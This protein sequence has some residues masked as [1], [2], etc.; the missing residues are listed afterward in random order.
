MTKFPLRLL[1]LLFLLAGWMHAATPVVSGLRV[2]GRVSPLG[3]DD[4][5]PALSWR[6]E[7]ADRGA[8]QTAYRVLVASTAE[9]LTQDRGDLWDTGRVESEDNL[10]LVYAGVQL[11]SHQAGFWKVQ[12][13]DEHGQSSSWSPVATW[14]AGV[15]AEKDWA[16]TTRWISDP[17][18]L[19]WQRAKLGYRSLP[20]AV[21]TTPKWIQ[22]DLGQSLP[23]TAVRLRGVTHTVDE[24]LGF[25]RRYQLEVADRADFS[26][27]R[28]VA[29]TDK[30]TNSWAGLI[31]LPLKDITARYVRFTATQLRV[32][33]GEACLAISQI[34]VL[35]GGRNIAPTAKITASDTLEDAS[36]SLAAINDGLGI[37]GVNP[38]ASD[39]LRLRRTF[40]VRPG[41]KRALLTISGLGHYTLAVNGAPTDANRLLTPGWTDYRKTCLY[42]TH[43]L[44]AQ[45]R[46]GA[47]ALGLTLGGGMYNVQTGFNRYIKFVSAYRPLMATGELR[48]EYADGTTDVISTDEHWRVTPGPITFSN[49]FGG[50][51][52]DA[53]REIPGWATAEFNDTAWTPA[54]VT[55][56]PGGKLRGAAWASPAL[57]AHESFAPVSVR[58]LSAGVSVYDFGQNVAMMPRLHVHGPAGAMVRMI[59][60]ELLQADGAVDRGSVGGGKAYWQY[61]LRGDAAGEFWFPDFFYQGARYLQVELTAPAG[62]ALPIM[63]KIES[64]VVHSDSPAAGSFACSSDLFNR[65]HTLVRWAQRSNFTHVISDCPHRERLGWLEQYHLNGPALRYEWDLT[66]LF[67]KGFNDIA[68]AQ[69]PNGLVPSIAPEYVV[70]DGGFVDSPEWGST[71]ILAAWQHYQFTGDDAPLRRHY[72][73][74]QRYFDY[75]T[76]RANHH[77]VSHGLGDWYDLGPKP[78][79]I[80]QLTPIAL[81][82]T[83]IYYED[84]RALARIAALI[85]QSADSNKYTAVAA[86]IGAAFNATFFNSQT[87]VYAAGSQTAQAMP[88]V[89]G[90][91]APERR[92]AVIAALLKDISDRGNAVTAGDVGYRYLLRAL[93]DTGHSD[94]IFEMNNQSEKPGYGYQLAHGATS[95]TEAWDANPH[96]SQNHFMLGQIMEWFYQDLAGLG[97]DPAVPGFKNVLVRP[98]PVGDLTWAEASHE[99]PYGLIKVRWE[100]GNGT[101]VLKVTV[102]ANATATVFVPAREAGSVRE[103]GAVAAQANGVKFLRREGDREVFAVESGSYGFESVW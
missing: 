29:S 82:A 48:L 16:A 54:A 24:N 58:E 23:I 99:S 46:P 61:T 69:R 90:L 26:D 51:D 81:T 55:V 96:S 68:D 72:A 25:P 45:L 89:L 19:R 63:E 21:A 91:V 73:A 20:S 2:G 37:P 36:W 15:L 70:F 65:I 44:T 18:L 6:M 93:A 10:R 101:F 59:P 86:E 74:M 39:T 53:R 56:G 33:H 84:A 52:Y 83:A 67:A 1:P 9:L 100:R 40:T 92:D 80:A 49:I 75:L 3:L 13:W 7:S 12:I 34:E 50:E 4:A 41:L 66:Q 95:L 14:T 62:A 27:A 38:R 79:G 35:S 102:P 5:R 17:E 64:V 78:P 22:L 42:D 47:N 60:A 11:R 97:V 30:E 87:G 98:Q 85:G 43:D 103:N 77:I 28:I 76:S 88:L 57:V 8:L 94:V 32:F 71:L 31:E